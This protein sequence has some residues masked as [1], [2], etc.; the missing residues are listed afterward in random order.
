LLTTTGL[1][2]RLALQ[3]SLP[4]S[5]YSNRA[6]GLF[7]KQLLDRLRALPG[8][9]LAAVTREAPLSGGQDASLN[10]IIENRAVPP[11]PEQPR[12]RYR[13]VS[14][15]YFDAM[16]IPLIRGR[17][18]DSTDGEA[19]PGVVL[20][21]ETLARRLWPNENPIG[22]RIKAGFDESQWCTIV[23]IV[24]DV[25]HT[26]LNAATN[27]E[28]YYH[29]LQVP[30]PWM[31][32]VE[33]TMTL[34]LRTNADPASLVAAV[35]G[36]VQK[37][38]RNIALFNVHTMDALLNASLTQPRFRTTLL[39]A[40]AGVAL[41]LA[42]IGLYGVIAYSVAQRTNELGVRMALGA[43]K[44][45]VLAMVLG[46][47]AILA[48]IGIAIG[49][50]VALGTMRV[51]SKLLFGVTATDPLTFAAAAA[52]IL[53]VA[54]VASLIPALRAIRVDAAA[55]LRYE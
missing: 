53:T 1:I 32:F 28:T 18:F 21:N 51:I 4:E 47:G 52:V 8:V 13:A 39:G 41:F 20:I 25:K 16:G 14:A 23:G 29:Y 19:T 30:P 6:V 10:F 48:V 5:R 54:L 24:A 43:Q 9:Q 46:H 7:Y 11:G 55:A 3:L 26:G 2:T 42:A 34:V 44:S 45:D 35:R 22:Q 27:P 15:D 37:L 49:L 50:L 33:G 40:F 38:D 17:R 36:E 12:A 31:S